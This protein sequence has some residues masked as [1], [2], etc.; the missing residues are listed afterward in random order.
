MKQIVMT[1]HK[2]RNKSKTYLSACDNAEAGNN[3]KHEMRDMKDAFVQKFK[4]FCH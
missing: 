2:I 4:L 3:I 1:K